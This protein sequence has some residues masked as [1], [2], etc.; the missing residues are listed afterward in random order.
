MPRDFPGTL[1]RV[2]EIGYEAVERVG[3]LGFGGL[4]GAEVRGL[5]DEMGLRVASIC[6]RA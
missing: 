4:S 5:L 6:H 1:Q 2:A 3:F